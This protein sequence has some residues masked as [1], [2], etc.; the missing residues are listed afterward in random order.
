[1]MSSAGAERTDWARKRNSN[2]ASKSSIPLGLHHER[3][4]YPL[5]T[6]N[7]QTTPKCTIS[8]VAAS[9][10]SDRATCKPHQSHQ[11]DKSKL[12]ENP[13]TDN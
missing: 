6:A 3:L 5:Y 9:D 10:A 11:V 2:V 7:E 12:A 4:L 13:T 8:A 1:M